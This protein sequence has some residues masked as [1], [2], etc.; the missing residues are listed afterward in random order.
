[1]KQFRFE[2][3][4]G[5]GAAISGTVEAPDK[6]AAL[7]KAREQC[8]VLVKIEP[9]HTGN[10]VDLLNT[11]MGAL[12]SG[13]RI[14]HKKLAILCAQLS[15]QLK[16]GMPLVRSLELAA[17]N[18]P[19]AQL[20]QILQDVVEDVRSGDSLADAFQSRGP[21]LPVAFIALIRAGE[22]S[23]T[24]DDALAR[25][26]TYYEDS[27]AVSAKVGSAMIY[28]A[29]LLGVAAIVIMVIMVYAVPVFQRSFASLGSEL[30]LPTRIL[31]YIS[32]FMS[33]HL[34]LLV[35][36]FSLAAM[37]LLLLSK[38]PAG[39][40]MFARLALDFP[41]LGQV[42]RM[43]A[44]ARFSATLAAMLEAGLPL[45]DAARIAAETAKN[46]LIAEAI[47]TACQ[48]VVE[49]NP[50]SRG[51]K[52]SRL[53]PELL[54]EMI[55]V[56][57]ETGSL[58]ETLRVVSAYYTGEVATAVKRALEILEPAITLTLAALVVFILLSVYLP[59]FGMYGAL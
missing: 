23:G 19:D 42:N 1:M 18:T 26:K 48:G 30:P 56:G 10:I 17:R 39:S 47:R 51:L 37:G 24:L 2:G 43:T 33:Q 52:E 28:P 20:Q 21:Q 22:A 53:L 15:I 44:A 35:A 45:V 55:A 29:M 34:A 41:G 40:R 9:I 38:S 16:A 57:E 5:S 7:A 46:M 50:L 12:L 8:R 13:G 32:T 31:M 4:S 14:P 27:A 54:T 58:E 49:G 6:A 59:I 36:I 25:L 3:L 11:D